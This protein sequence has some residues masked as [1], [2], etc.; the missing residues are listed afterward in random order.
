MSKIRK[1]YWI[2]LYVWILMFIFVFVLNLIY[3]FLDFQDVGILLAGI[4]VTVSILALGL[5]D[6]RKPRFKGTVEV[7]NKRISTSSSI[8]SAKI[9]RDSV[10][11]QINNRGSDPVENFTINIRIPNKVYVKYFDAKY[12]NTVRFGETVI[13]IFDTLRFLGI[14]APDNF[15]RL[16]PSFSLDN[17]EKGNFYITISGDNIAPTTY[18][19]RLEQKEDLI[20]SNSKKKLKLK[21]YG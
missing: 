17:W 14:E 11:I 3:S 21:V 16:E 9:Y 7:W 19:I 15:I 13:L 5:A 12:F 6:P 4:S 1:K 2:I 10:K 8:E 20:A 18:A